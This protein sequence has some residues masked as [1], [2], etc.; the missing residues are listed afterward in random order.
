MSYNSYNLVLAVTV[1]DGKLHSI[2]RLS[3]CLRSL[4]HRL[5]LFITFTGKAGRILLMDKL[6]WIELNWLEIR[7]ELIIYDCHASG[8]GGCICRRFILIFCLLMFDF[9]WWLGNFDETWY[10]CWFLDFPLE[11][12]GSD[13]TFCYCAG[14]Y[15]DLR[16]P[17]RFIVKIRWWSFLNLFWV[18]VISFWDGSIDGSWRFCWDFVWNFYF[19]LTAA[20]AK[21]AEFFLWLS[22]KLRVS[23]RRLRCFDMTFWALISG[24]LVGIDFDWDSFLRRGR[25]Y[26]IVGVLLFN[27]CCRSPSACVLA[28]G[29]SFCAREC[30]GFGRFPLSRWRAHRCHHNFL[31]QIVVYG[32]GDI[33]LFDFV[34]WDEFDWILFWIVS[35]VWLS[36]GLIRS[37][38]DFWK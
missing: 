31:L 4:L 19:I 30:F 8:G 26:V 33:R 3:A 22:Y 14:F 32:P 34:K 5:W 13:G 15:E 9:F 29:W 27:S 10:F 35:K 28:L 11:L 12:G 23:G 2:S 25:F 36:M 6:N 37:R 7:L 16:T 21:A 17:F 18:L 24:F 1:L 38:F 20:S